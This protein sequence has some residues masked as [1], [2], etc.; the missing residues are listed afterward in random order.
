MHVRLVS[1]YAKA[2][3][4][5]KSHFIRVNIDELSKLLL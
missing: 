3:S 1:Y 4:G 2:T 5:V